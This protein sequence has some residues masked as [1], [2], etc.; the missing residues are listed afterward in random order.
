MTNNILDLTSQ[1]T[2]PASRPRNLVNSLTQLKNC[3]EDILYRVDVD[4]QNFI[5]E[6]HNDVMGPLCR[7]VDLPRI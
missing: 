4:T 5:I 2:I 3:I 6:F 1:A 7:F